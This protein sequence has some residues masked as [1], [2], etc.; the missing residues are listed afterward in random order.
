[1]TDRIGRNAILLLILVVACTPGSNRRTDG[2]DSPS[3]RPSGPLPS[4]TTP[5]RTISIDTRL[6]A[7]D[8]PT[9]LAVDSESV[10]I[11][12]PAVPDLKDS[13]AVEFRLGV[14]ERFFAVGINPTDIAAGLGAAWVA[15]GSGLGTQYTDPNMAP[16]YPRENSVQRIGQA[17][18]GTIQIEDPIQLVVGH[19]S[20]WVASSGSIERGSQ[21]SRIDARSNRIV[22]S[23]T[24]QGAGR[25]LGVTRAG[26]WMLTELDKGLLLSQINPVTM[27]IVSKLALDLPST[28]MLAANGDLVAV[29]AT[30]A[31]G[32]ITVIDA[33]TGNSRFLEGTV[34]FPLAAALHDNFLWLSLDAPNIQVVDLSIG[35]IIS[36][37]PLDFT[38]TDLEAHESSV[39]AAAEGQLARLSLSR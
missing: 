5:S 9:G 19:G 13:K 33:V 36:S 16:G 4:L 1:M 23:L 31:T 29:V 24:L 39:W 18:S 3:G 25:R 37:L 17:A 28:S 2:I 6:T 8:T 27:R 26:V 30:G 14:E 21:L 10:W 15:N 34:A 32:K 20:V 7:T 11:V 22:G 38:V 12:G 35:R